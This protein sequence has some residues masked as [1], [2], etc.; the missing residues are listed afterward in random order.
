[1]TTSGALSDLYVDGIW[2]GSST[3]YDTVFD[4]KYQINDDG[5]TAEM[6]IPYSVYVFQ[7]QIQDWGINFGRDLSGELKEGIYVES[8][9][10]KN[11]S[12]EESM[13]VVKNI[14]NIDPPVRLFFYPYLQSA[15]NIQNKLKPSSS[16]FSW[17]RLKI[18]IV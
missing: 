13:G 6:I 12:Y 11:E 15:V 8:V 9:D 4:S 14:Q 1:M 7:K 18:W 5:W 17:I 10:L 2:D 3:N 16:L